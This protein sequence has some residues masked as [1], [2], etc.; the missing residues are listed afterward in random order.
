[1]PRAKKKYEKEAVHLWI[2]IEEQKPF[3][4]NEFKKQDL[5]KILGLS[6][7]QLHTMLMRSFIVIHSQLMNSLRVEEAKKLHAH[8]SNTGMKK[9]L[10]AERA[11]FTSMS[12]F[13][14]QF[15]LVTG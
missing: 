5:C 15:K 2:F 11:G 12:Q 8:P 13:Y 3:L 14:V 10:L 1:M 9:D 6:V 4:K 7:S